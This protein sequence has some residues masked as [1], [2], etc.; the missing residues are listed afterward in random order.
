MKKSKNEKMPT[1]LVTGS[2]RGIG[3]AIAQMFSRNSF[4]VI[5]TGTKLQNVIDAKSKVGLN[6]VSALELDLCNP[7][8]IENF[9]NRINKQTIDVVVHNAGM[10][11]LQNWQNISSKRWEQMF[12]VNTLGPMLISKDII[13]SMRLRN[14]GQILFFS[15]PFKIDDKVKLIGPYMQTKLAQTTFMHSLAYSLKDTDISVNS[16]WTNFPI[17]TDAISHRNVTEK[18]SC[19]SP[20]IIADMVE[21]I[22]FNENPKTFRG[23]EII[24]VDYLQNTSR[25]KLGNRVQNLDRVFLDFLKQKSS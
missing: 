8:S 25:Y 10:L 20:K 12:R 23:N 2:S 5:I 7:Q 3:L 15:P 22:V 14:K 16:F 21:N 13:T 18:E 6:N 24:D 17:Y 19:M 11:S 4:N 1:A 9:R